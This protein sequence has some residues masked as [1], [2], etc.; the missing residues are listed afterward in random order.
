MNEVRISAAFRGAS[1]GGRVERPRG[2]K[3]LRDV[4]REPEVSWFDTAAWQVARRDDCGA[5]PLTPACGCRTPGCCEP[6]AAA[7]ARTR[8]DGAADPGRIPRASPLSS[9]PSSQTTISR[10]ASACP[11]AAAPVARSRDREGL[12]TG[13]RRVPDSPQ[14]RNASAPSKVTSPPPGSRAM[15]ADA[16]S[17]P[18]NRRMRRRKRPPKGCSRRMGTDATL[19]NRSARLLA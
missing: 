17:S 14:T 1:G 4:S 12:R 19:L 10:P 2:F 7:P 3:E 15:K 11:S 13:K 5:I 8:G 9:C 16:G 6:T 18:R